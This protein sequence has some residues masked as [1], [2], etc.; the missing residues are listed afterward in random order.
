[1]RQILAGVCFLG[2][3][4]FLAA[5]TYITTDML[6]ALTWLGVSWC[7]V[8]LMQRRRMNAGGSPSA[9]CRLQPVEQNI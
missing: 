2:A 3:G 8:R 1:L 9:D 5:G 7:L 4:Y 6:Q